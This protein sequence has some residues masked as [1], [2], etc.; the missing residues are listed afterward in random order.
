MSNDICY[1]LLLEISYI[2]DKY[3]SIYYKWND[4]INGNAINK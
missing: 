1:K 4:I 3:I 2:W